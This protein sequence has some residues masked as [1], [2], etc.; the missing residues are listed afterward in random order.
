MKKDEISKHKLLSK[1]SQGETDFVIELLFESFKKLTVGHSR[2]KEIERE[3]SKLI[4]LSG[5]NKDLHSQY[6]TGVLSPEVFLEK[7]I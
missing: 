1:L 5:R 6:Q 4:L 7:K 2:K 3:Y